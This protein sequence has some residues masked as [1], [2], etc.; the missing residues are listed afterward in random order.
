MEV[1]GIHV[2]LEVICVC[3]C[4]CVINISKYIVHMTEFSKKKIKKILVTI[5]LGYHFT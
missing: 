4:M 2:E 3:M 5:F 1:K